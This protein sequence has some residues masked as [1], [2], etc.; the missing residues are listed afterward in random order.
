M[1]IGCGERFRDPGLQFQPTAHPPF[2]RHDTS[3]W[4]CHCYELSGGQEEDI[5]LI[6]PVSVSAKAHPAVPILSQNQRTIRGAFFVT[7]RSNM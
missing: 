6:F 3:A 4:R 2:L 1:R 7:L 5:A